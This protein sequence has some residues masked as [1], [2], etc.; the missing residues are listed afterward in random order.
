MNT[1]AIFL[2]KIYQNTLSKI[3]PGRCRFYPSCSQYAIECFQTFSFFK[4]FYKSSFRIIRCNPF[5]EGYFD[6]VIP[7]DNQRIH[8]THTHGK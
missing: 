1:L 7:D 3:L 5:S 8:A 6:P 4:A 2:I